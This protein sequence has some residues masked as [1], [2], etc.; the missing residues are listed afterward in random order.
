MRYLPKILLRCAGSILVFVSSMIFPVAACLVVALHSDD[1]SWSV[2]IG[3][4][5]LLGFLIAV[6]RLPDKKEIDVCDHRK[7]KLR[8]L[9]WVLVPVL[10]G[11]VLRLPHE[12]I[13]IFLF[14]LGIGHLLLTEQL[15]QLF[16][17][18]IWRKNKI[19][20]V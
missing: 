12:N 4:P 20:M 17:S 7:I 3:V 18:F 14:I 6:F 5:S 8:V 1:P 11:V 9:S 19:V 10:F 16:L 15:S 2:I 13:I